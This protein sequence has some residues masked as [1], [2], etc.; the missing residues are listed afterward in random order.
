MTVLVIGIRLV[1]GKHHFKFLYVV[2]K[3]G[4]GRVWRVEMKKTRKHYALK[5]MAKSKLIYD[6]YYY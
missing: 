2:G 3:G 6:Y 1:V 4:F 5:E